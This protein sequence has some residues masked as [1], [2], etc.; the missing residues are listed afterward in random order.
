MD[1]LEAGTIIKISPETWFAAYLSQQQSRIYFDFQTM[2]CGAETC[3]R[4]MRRNRERMYF[5]DTLTSSKARA[6][7]DVYRACEAAYGCGV[8]FL[9]P[10]ILKSH[11]QRFLVSSNRV[12]LVPLDKACTLIT[13]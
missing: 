9:A 4:A 13:E 8:S 6:K 3:N 10:D 11:P 1:Y 7:N 12:L 2:G 5:T